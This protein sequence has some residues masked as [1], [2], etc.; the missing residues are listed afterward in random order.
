[1]VLDKCDKTLC[2]KGEQPMNDKMRDELKAQI[3][4]VAS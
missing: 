3:K 2:Q 4:K 1:M